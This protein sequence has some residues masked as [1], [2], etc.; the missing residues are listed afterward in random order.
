MNWDKLEKN[1]G[2]RVQ[3]APPAIHLDA[4]G[5]ELPE[6]NEDWII[7]SV[8]DDEVC[9]DE[10]TSRALTT[11]I[12]KDSIHEFNHNAQRSISGGL[13]Y[14]FLSLK[15]QMTIEGDIIAYRPCRPR[16]RV[17]P[18]PPALE[19]DLVEITYPSTTDLQ[20]RLEA[21]G[22]QVYW[23]GKKRVRRRESEGWEIVRE[24]DV[25]GVLQSFC[26]PSG[27]GDLILMKR[28]RDR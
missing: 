26:C 28:R 11:R 4:L 14:G 21:A 13:Q 20:S 22:F 17:A 1:L 10:A 3:L 23:S 16:E 15:L 7:R 25:H 12:A 19:E 2:W 27:D 8:S 5:R 18:P 6:R 24:R 9:L